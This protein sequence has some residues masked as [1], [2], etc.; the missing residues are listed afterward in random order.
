MDCR[1]SGTQSPRCT[2]R[3]EEVSAVEE[4]LSRYGARHLLGEV[5][6]EYA[7]DGPRGGKPELRT[8]LWNPD[9]G[10]STSGTQSRH[11]A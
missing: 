10:G 8:R 6:L 4:I 11:R 7:A 5:S 9:S 2:G 1:L 3:R